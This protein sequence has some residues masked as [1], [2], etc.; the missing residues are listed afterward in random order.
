[1]T[2]EVLNKLVTSHNDFRAREAVD[3][4]DNEYFHRRDLIGWSAWTL[5]RLN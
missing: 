5:E 2:A 4:H 3:H 1:M